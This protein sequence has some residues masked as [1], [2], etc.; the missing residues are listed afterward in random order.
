[1]RLIAV[2]VNFI[3]DAVEKAVFG[4]LRFVHE[5]DN[6]KYRRRHDRRNG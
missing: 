6:P 4:F 2:T 3:M 5:L 1:M